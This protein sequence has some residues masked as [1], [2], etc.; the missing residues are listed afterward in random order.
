MARQQ[1]EKLRQEEE[2]RK[3]AADAAEEARKQAEAKRQQVLASAKDD[4]KKAIASKVERGWIRP[5]SSQ[6]RLK[7]TIKVKLL[8]DGT[9]MEARVVSSSGDA[10]FDR[11]AELA[12][13]KASPLP[14]PRDR[15]LFNKEFKEFNFD[16]EPH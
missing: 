8:S 4:A 11:S 2:S 14:I 13:R 12:V 7:C 1:A 15:E 9:V 16:F 5:F 3:Q 10:A 6:G